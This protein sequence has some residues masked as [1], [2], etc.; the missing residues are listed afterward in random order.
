MRELA[1]IGLL[2]ICVAWSSASAQTQSPQKPSELAQTVSDAYKEKKLAD[3]DKKHLAAGTITVV[4]EH[5]LIEGKNGNGLMKVRR[6]KNLAAIDKWLNSKLEE[7]GTPFRQTMPLLKCSRGRCAFNF[8]GG[9][10]HNQLYLH[11]LYY[12]SRNGRL[13]ITKLHLLDGD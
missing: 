2:L 13:Y 12:S 6:F 8:D 10:L 4:I 11:D 1:P 7:D 3:L 5:S 9:I